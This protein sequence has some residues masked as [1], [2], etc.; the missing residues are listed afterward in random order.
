M[1]EAREELPFLF[2]NRRLVLRNYNCSSNYKIKEVTFDLFLVTE[3]N[4]NK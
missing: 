4:E 1:K 3:I 2:L